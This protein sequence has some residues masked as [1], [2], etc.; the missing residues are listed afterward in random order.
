MVVVVSNLGIDFIVGSAGVLL[1]SRTLRLRRRTSIAF[2]FAVRGVTES[3]SGLRA[4]VGIFVPGPYVPEQVPLS[5]AD[6]LNFMWIATLVLPMASGLSSLPP[7]PAKTNCVLRPEDVD[8]VSISAPVVHQYTDRW[9]MWF[10][11]RSAEAT[12]LPPISSGRIYVAESPDGLDWTVIGEVLAE[13]TEWWGFDN[14]HVGLGD[15][16]PLQLS[17]DV[18]EAYRKFSCASTLQAKA[19]YYFGGAKGET[20]LRDLGIDRDGTVP[21]MDLRVGLAVSQGDIDKFA[22]VEGSF[23]TGEIVSVGDAWD[24]AYLGWPAVV[25]ADQKRYLS[26]QALN[27][28]SKRHAVGLAGGNA[29]AFD[30]L[31]RSQPTFIGDEVPFSANGVSRRCLRPCLGGESCSS[32]EAFQMWFEGLSKDGRH[33]IGVART[34]SDFSTWSIH[35]DPVLTPST[36]LDAWDSGTVSAPFVCRLDDTTLRL[37]YSGS[38]AKAN[39]KGPTRLSIGVAESTDDGLSWSRV[40]R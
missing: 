10:H 16:A 2:R 31:S 24:V 33:A 20:L 18:N 15:V 38:P 6:D 37:Y 26:Y 9:T 5:K 1:D 4:I 29:I 36:D 7:L 11:G 22:R 3:S 39:L 30:K 12:G 32:D 35:S 28:N 14:A 13:N 34:D 8:L 19:M 25:D 27:K 40:L 21:A 23:A 17:S